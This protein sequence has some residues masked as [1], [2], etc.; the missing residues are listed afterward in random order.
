MDG[1][2][3]SNQ[4]EESGAVRK[5][6]T[7]TDKDLDLLDEQNT[8]KGKWAVDDLDLPDIGSNSR[9]TRDPYRSTAGYGTGNRQK[10]PAGSSQTQRR[11]SGNTGSSQAP[12]RSSGNTGSSQASRRSSG[13]TGSSQASRRSSGNTGSSQPQRRSS[14]KT[15]GSQISGRSSGN[16]GR[17]QTERKT[18]GS[19]RSAENIPEEKD[20]RSYERDRE[21]RESRASRSKE[22]VK[23][24]RVSKT[25]IA[26]S[27][28]FIG[29]AAGILLIIIVIIIGTRSCSSNHKSAQNVVEEL[30]TAF[31]DGNESKMK[32]SYGIS[33]D[34]AS[35]VQEELDAAQAYY[36]AHNAK[37][38]EI[39]NTGSLFSEGKYIY[40]YI[41]YDLVLEN[42]QKYPCIGTYIVQNIEDKYYVLPPSKVTEDLSEKA[43]AAYKK[44]MNTD[45]YKKYTMDYAF[46]FPLGL[47]LQE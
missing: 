14:G 43:T 33:E 40:V 31:V 13:N 36:S 30:I 16:S 46:S 45:T 23:R 3:N 26:A 44:F 11:S 41:V 32:D 39:T 10:R 2:G 4:T 5:G 29:V 8:D 15:G 38:L 47:L 42:D 7:Q 20:I 27:P 9:Q 24:K 1:R 34:D 17:V 25:S 19:T 6:N 21:E 22:S 28:L 18:S 37:K 12:R 35:D